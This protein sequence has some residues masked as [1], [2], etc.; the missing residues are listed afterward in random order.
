MTAGPWLPVVEKPLRLLGACGTDGR[1]PCI[2]DADDA[3]RHFT[4][5]KAVYSHVH[6]TYD[7]PKSEADELR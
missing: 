5:G 1:A 4:V 2:I 6:F 3:S 7:Q